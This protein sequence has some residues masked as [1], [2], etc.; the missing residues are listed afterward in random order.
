MKGT[1]NGKKL[2]SSENV[3]RVLS[4]PTTSGRRTGHNHV[5]V[6]ATGTLEVSPKNR[7]TDAEAARQG[8]M[9]H[10]HVVD[11]SQYDLVYMPGFG[12]QERPF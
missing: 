6:T 9:T 2:H 1:T 4:R 10:I 3:P 12:L 5:G 7:S 11:L 8:C